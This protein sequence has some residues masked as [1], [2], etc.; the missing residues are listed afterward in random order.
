MANHTHV[1]TAALVTASDQAAEL[2]ERLP[3]AVQVM[4]DS[5]GNLKGTD[6]T[7]GGRSSS[8]THSDP[9]AAQAGTRD[10]SADDLRRAQTL[11]R[12]VLDA[13]RRLDSI[14]TTYSPTAEQ[15]AAVRDGGHLGDDIWCDNH[16]AHGF[17]EVRAPKRRTC[18]WCM[19]IKHRH[20]DLP[21]LALIEAH[22]RMPR[23][24]EQDV[25]RLLRKK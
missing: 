25:K 6:T 10:R 11:I 12:D 2:A 17:E 21:N 18:S 20:G 14:I 8:G 24:T 23:L 5:R 9:T 13:L 4:R 16:L 19:S 3:R 15:E 1:L 22:Y 7:T